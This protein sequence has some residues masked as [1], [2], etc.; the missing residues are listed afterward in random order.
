[1]DAAF[2]EGS[3][4]GEALERLRANMELDGGWYRASPHATAEFLLDDFGV[5][6]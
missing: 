5:T 4:A 1:M 3:S 6:L 2:A